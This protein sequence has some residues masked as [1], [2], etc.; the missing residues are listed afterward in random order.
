MKI[1]ETALSHYLIEHLRALT[2]ADPA[3]L[4]DYVTA[5]LKNNKP[6]E[7]LKTLCLDQL[8]DFLGE[9]TT[10][11][12]V[13]LFHAI[14]DGRISSSMEDLEVDKSQ[15]DLEIV[16]GALEVRISPSHL[17]NLPVTGA[18]DCEDEVEEEDSSDDD[19]N[20][21]HRRRVSRSR[22][23][24]RADEPNVSRYIGG[25]CKDFKRQVGDHGRVG[26]FDR[27]RP[28]KL[29]KRGF[30]DAG[31]RFS[32]ADQAERGV[33]RGG[34]PP[35]RADAPNPRLDC[36][37]KGRGRGVCNRVGPMP[38]PFGDAPPMLPLTAGFFPN[39]RG[40]G[41]RGT[42]WPG[43]FGP[44]GG[45][46][47]GMGAVSLEHSHAGRGPPGVMNLAM[48][49]G[50]GAVRPRCLDFEERGFCLRGDL[51]PMDHGSHIVVEDVQSLSKFNLPVNFSNGRGM[52][53]ALGQMANT[54]LPM[55]VS[56]TNL[57]SFTTL[58]SRGS[59]GSGEP[60]ISSSKVPIVP[61][62]Q[63]SAEPDLYDP[64]Q[65]LWNEERPEA[66]GRISKLSAF[67]VDNSQV[68]KE[69]V[70]LRAV[71]VNSRDII[72]SGLH[73]ADAGSTV[74][75]RI[76][77]VDVSAARVEGTLE[78]QRAQGRGILWQS[79][80]WGERE[81]EDGATTEN[82]GRGRGA[83]GW[84]EVGP[85]FNRPKDGTN[86][87]FR[88]L[89]RSVERAQCTLY[90]SCIPPS[91]N[92]PEVLL[93]HFEKFG[94]VVDV[95]I[96]PHSD[97]AFVQFATREEA[98]L[99]LASPDAVMRNRFIRLSWANRDSVTSDT[100]ASTSFTGQ[101]PTTGIERTGGHAARLVN[102]RGKP[103]FFGLNG[104]V[105]SMSGASMTEGSRK[106]TISADS[107]SSLATSVIMTSKKQE[108]LE[109]MRENIRLKQEALARK[110]DD[111]RRKLDRLA[112]QGVL[113]IEDYFGDQANKRQRVKIS[114]NAKVFGKVTAASSVSADSGPRKSGSGVAAQAGLPQ[115][116]LKPTRSPHPR[117]TGVSA[118]LP[119]APWA[120]ARYKLDNRTTSFKILPPL[121]STITDVAAVRE[122]FA[123][124]GELS[125]V[126]FEDV[127]SFNAASTRSFDVN[128]TI[129][130]SFTTRWSA[131]RAMAL[132]KWFHGQTFNLAW[133]STSS[134][135]RP[136]DSSALAFKTTLL[137]DET[138]SR[139]DANGVTEEASVKE[140][141]LVDDR[142]NVV[143]NSLR[144]P[145]RVL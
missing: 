124:F 78:E 105:A 91:S 27:E 2:E 96:P 68:E 52:V 106:A 76:G 119:V 40:L 81:R 139:G 138:S 46:G 5:L 61:N 145:A 3:L 22:S 94:R 118:G 131:E 137:E 107:A 58:S 49:V 32:H 48:G 101:L 117:T 128:N 92:R 98:E 122:H 56:N 86:L 33:L 7:E 53:L 29:E 67:Q 100:C 20:H 116:T 39:G 37:R 143:G 85:P 50:I 136:P 66:T 60:S 57:P 71:D 90:V 12:V 34:C 140:Q 64:D 13:S 15:D 6:K 112:S 70:D 77:P 59:R 87:G 133:V 99:A 44:M 109:L 23:T 11:F 88:V 135:S 62:D 47:G 1:D 115:A 84:A 104:V 130:V 18:Q 121:P 129:R 74:W 30:R 120:P 125:S 41:G 103:S 43:S 95:R 132:G 141:H 28:S 51:C 63:V 36:G 10:S 54:N 75:D 110:R 31:G 144:S 69:K 24:D 127:G 113:G 4:A 16:A 26:Q 17:E 93:M 14:D 19:R 79:E 35:F 123:V 42:G 102:S 45:I 83:A 114:G 111:F 65:P 9:G 126:E 82:P 108:E 55:A 8:H 25:A 80:R 73:A 142:P 134:I 72:Y 89:A 97:R 21:K 38:P